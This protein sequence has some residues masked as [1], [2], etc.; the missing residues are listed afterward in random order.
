MAVA[1]LIPRAM[2]S[3]AS[4]FRR[5]WRRKDSSRRR[6]NIPARKLPGL[7]L[8]V[9]RADHDTATCFLCPQRNGVAAAALAYALRIHR[10]RAVLAD[11]S[12]A[13][14]VKAHSSADLAGVEDGRNFA[15]RLTI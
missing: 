14:F 11:Q 10:R 12:A 13:S 15:V 6:S 8:G 9:G 7:G 5:F 3:S 1:M 4:D 2:A